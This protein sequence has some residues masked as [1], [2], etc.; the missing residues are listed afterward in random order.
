MFHAPTPA[1]EQSEALV[2]VTAQLPETQG[3][4]QHCHGPMVL[5][6]QLH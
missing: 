5:C 1:H 4:S 2:W 6:V 3:G